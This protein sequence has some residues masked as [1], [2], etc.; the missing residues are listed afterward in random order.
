MKKIKKNTSLNSNL[1]N[2]TRRDLFEKTGT[3]LQGTALAWILGSGISSGTFARASTPATYDL[4]PKK[5]HM[6]PKAT[7]VIQ[8]F[9]II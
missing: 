3:L 1:E 5:P 2:V 8:L 4:S 7:A 6:E 9:I